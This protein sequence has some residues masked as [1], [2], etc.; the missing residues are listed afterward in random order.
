[1]TRLTLDRR[2]VL[3][4][5]L[6]LPLAAC[7]T[8]DPAILDGIIGAGG[9]FGGLSQAEAAQ[10]IRAALASGVV[11]AITQVGR[12][13]GYFQDGKI[14][15]PLPQTLQD[16]QSV[17]APIGFGGLLSDLELQLNR[18]AEK[19]APFAKDL[20]T[21]VIAGVTITDAIN[22]VRGSSNA[23][24]TYLADKTMPRLVSLFSPIMT[25]ALQG[26]GALQLVDQ[27][28]SQMAAVP[29]APQLGADAKSD[30]I[31]Y[32]VRKGL[33]GLFVYIGEQEAA[34]RAN[35]AERTSEILRRVFGGQV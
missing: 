22:I 25:D 35:P 20:F 24:T 32:G 27:L 23:A 18:G 1:M 33:E 4:A 11:S 21:D 2:A 10:G 29:F 7:E 34:I 26:T 16:V 12:E 5:A 17:L 6:G 14:K 3:A 8:V 31:D 13:G 19:A 15:I 30:L 9:G 28:S